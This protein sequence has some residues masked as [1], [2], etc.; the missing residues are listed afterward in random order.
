MKKVFSTI[1]AA[2]L[3]LMGTNAT[4]QISVGAGYLNSK[5]T[6]KVSLAGITSIEP[7]ANLNGFYVGGAY[8][9]PIGTSGLGVAP[10]LYFSYQ[11]A[12]DVKLIKVAGY[13]LKLDRMSESYLAVPIDVNFR[14]ALTDD[15]KG[16]IYAGPTFSYGISSKIK[17]DGT[18]Y[19]I[20]SGDLKNGDFETSSDYLKDFADYKHF[21][22][23]LGGGVGV[24]F[25]NQF[26]FKVG[27]DFG[28]LDRGPSDV[29]IKRNQLTLGVAYLF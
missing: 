11:G 10:G 9:I 21:D 4:A 29:K 8:N 3:M 18:V 16:L 22:I 2:S 1:L 7:E 28:L 5:T 26:R 24:E 12:N 15:I 17:Y 25:F 6:L 14:L 19:N 13:E 27:Y 23:L 20:Y